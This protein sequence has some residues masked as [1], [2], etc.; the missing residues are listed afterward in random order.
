MRITAKGKHQQ[1]RTGHAGARASA[2]SWGAREQRHEA[3]EKA[4]RRTAAGRS[5]AAD[6]TRASATAPEPSTADSDVRTKPT[7]R[8]SSVLDHDGPPETHGRTRAFL[9][10]PSPSLSYKRH[11]IHISFGYSPRLGEVP[12][13]GKP[14]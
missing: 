6:A 8:L 4:P 3:A 2:P 10:T 5:W 1:Q 7:T 9:L 14:Q 11:R 13:G 12:G